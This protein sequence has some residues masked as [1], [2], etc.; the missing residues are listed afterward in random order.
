MRALVSVLALVVLLSGCTGDEPDAAPRPARSSVASGTASGA[1]SGVAVGAVSPAAPD[2]DDPAYDVALS[3]TREDSVYPDVGDPGVDALHY[4]LDLTW[5]ADDRILTGVATVV[6]RSTASAQRLQLDLGEALTV[7]SVRLD[8]TL[9]DF[10]HPGKDLVVS[11]PVEQDRRYVLQVDYSGTPLPAAAPTTRSDFATTGF[12]ITP[13][14]EVWT[15]QEPYGAYTWY[16]VND[17]PADKALYDIT[18]H[19][20]GDW[21]GIANGVLRDRRVDLDSSG[22]NVVATTT[23]WHL[24]EPA[25]SYLVTLAIG[26]YDETTDT[27]SN[28]VPISYWTPRDRPDLVDGLRS[29]PAAV[30]WLEAR[31]GP[32]PFDSLGIVLVDSDSGMETQ[33]MITLGIGDYTTSPAV[34]L[35]EIAH[36]W[37]GDRVTPDDWRDVWM[38]EG[39]AMYLQSVWQGEQDGQDYLA[40]LARREPGERAS[41]GPPAAYDPST[42][43]ESNIYYGPAMMW[44]AL[45]ER[46]GEQRFAD[47]VRRWPIRNDDRSV[48]REDY[49]AWLVRATG[50]PRSFFDDWLLS[51]TSPLIRS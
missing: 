9:V 30:D 43:G 23:D 11:A 1:A 44:R 45:R 7:T 17:Q 21:V 37:Y 24:A 18:V 48:G 4:G 40:A 34:V 12:T 20:P 51:P 6:L 26:A 27:S 42:F 25:A 39:M 15:M 47:V 36:Q 50:Q 22:G 19:A 14:G 10:T 35:H 46:I 8:G 16:P 49:L 31:L 5:D 33:T 29:A 28:G 2:P 13:T 41:A 32:Y 3:T 38:N